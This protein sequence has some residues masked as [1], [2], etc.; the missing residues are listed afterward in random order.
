VSAV[1]LIC[2]AFDV[3]RAMSTR[4]D[5]PER[6]CRPFDKDRDGFVMAEGAAIL[7][8]E[9]LDHAV[10]RDAP[11]YGEILGYGTTND[12]SLVPRALDSCPWG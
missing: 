12:A 1:P 9:A 8:L 3:I 5:D 2:G 4:N 11:I 6:A 7:V 10:R